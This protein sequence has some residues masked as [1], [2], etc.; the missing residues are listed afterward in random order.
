MERP[1]ILKA[2]EVCGILDGRQTQLRRIV[3]PQPAYVANGTPYHSGEQDDVVKCPFGKVGDRLWGRETWQAFEKDCS[4]I[5]AWQAT[6][7]NDEFDYWCGNRC[8]RLTIKKWR[9]SVIMP[10]I[11]SRIL[12]EIV[13]VRVERLQDISDHDAGES[14]IYETEFYDNAEHKVSGG[15]PYSEERL[16]FADM[17][18]KLHATSE[19]DDWDAN[20]SVWV[21]IF[22]R[23]EA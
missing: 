1:I 4:T 17:W 10:R 18:Q 2:H 20:P 15:A 8:E 9:S 3:K 21:L 16:A 12:L 13:S 11:A 19:R 23:V 7:E 14:G 5:V 22:K 6:C